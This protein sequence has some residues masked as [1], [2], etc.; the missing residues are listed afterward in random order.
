MSL[1]LV[2]C[3]VFKC[4][5]NQ[6]PV[7]KVAKW[8]L[9]VDLIQ[10]PSP[11]CFRMSKATVYATSNGSAASPG[12][13]LGPDL[14]AP[15]IQYPA[16]TPVQQP[17]QQIQYAP[18]QQQQVQLQ[19]FT[20]A[21]QQVQTTITTQRTVTQTAHIEQTHE[22]EGD[23]KTWTIEKK[24]SCPCGC[25]QTTWRLHNKRPLLKIRQRKSHC[26]LW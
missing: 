22:M 19:Q 16:P 3:A 17:V 10:C 15:M 20:A 18:P 4:E 26:C 1:L 5:L 23:Y 14:G 7:L 25:E 13:N 12:P 24:C 11:V 8:I 21:P 9:L 6:A 2:D